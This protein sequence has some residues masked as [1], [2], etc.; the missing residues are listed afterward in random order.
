VRLDVR[1]G[2]GVHFAAQRQ[3]R[4][5]VLPGDAV[6]EVA[7]GFDFRIFL[8]R[9]GRGGDGGQHQQPGAA[10]EVGLHGMLGVLG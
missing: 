9:G 10:A 3:R 2:G 8:A 7:L 4:E 1:F 6:G 5:R